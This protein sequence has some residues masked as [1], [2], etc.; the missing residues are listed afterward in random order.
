MARWPQQAYAPNGC[1][2]HTAADVTDTSAWQPDS[3]CAKCNGCGAAFTF[4]KRRH[5]CRRCA[6]IFC[7]D[8]SSRRAVLPDMHPS[9]AQRVCDRCFAHVTISWT[10]DAKVVS[11]W[12]PLEAHPQSPPDAPVDL[13][14]HFSA[15]APAP[16]S[17]HCR[18][19][20]DA[21]LNA[22]ISIWVGDA[23]HLR[24]DAVAVEAPK[25]FAGAA[26]QTPR[27]QPFDTFSQLAGRQFAGLLIPPYA[28][29]QTPYVL[30][31]ELRFLDDC[32]VGDVK[33]VKGY[34]LP[35]SNV[36]LVGCPYYRRSHE[37]ASL[38]GLH[39]CYRRS[40]EF[41]IDCSA[42]T[43]GIRSTPPP[44]CAAAPPHAPQLPIPPSQ[45]VEGQRRGARG[46][47]HRAPQPAAPRL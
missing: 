36:L 47:A 29:P 8:C 7:D 34:H 14:S 37:S 19:P 40:I 42:S 6:W 33:L 44:P 15:P 2:H 30:A 22:K 24:A 32:R 5:H 23:W 35:C 1:A 13:S 31:D 9:H 3:E 46:A 41:A 26:E 28:E 10:A 27:L 17:S 45:A 16:S 25:S 39:Q 4:S 18:Y 12:V 43:L 38:S 21:A 20:V 11:P